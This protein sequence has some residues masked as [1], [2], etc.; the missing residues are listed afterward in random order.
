MVNF[1][2]NVVSLLVALGEH[3]CYIVGKYVPLKDVLDVHCVE[4]ALV[5][6]PKGVEIIFMGNFN[7]RL[8]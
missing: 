1:G 8:R 3:I 7:V 2:P 4:Q 6:V 5:A